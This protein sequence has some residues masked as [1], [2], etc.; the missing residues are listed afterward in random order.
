[1]KRVNLLILIIITLMII[2]SCGNNSTDPDTEIPT[3]SISNPIDNAVLASNSIVTITID[4]QDN[5]E[6]DSLE[7]YID[8]TLVFTDEESPYQYD[9]DTTDIFGEH[10]IYAK[11]FDSSD[12]S[13]TSAEITVTLINQLE[14]LISPYESVI[15]IDEELE[16]SIQVENVSDLF[17]FSAEIVFDNSIIEP[18]PDMLTI[19]SIWGNDVVELIVLENGRINVAISLQQTPGI[20]E[21]NGNEELLTFR[22]I[23]LQAGSS[24]LSFENVQMLDENGETISNFDDL[25]ITNGEITIE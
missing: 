14:L 25:E 21:I 2:I 3:I 4:A 10:T 11:A 18:V 5:E 9:W 16:V 13:A 1:M 8:S 19:G 7:L 24:S 15:S 6:I 12:N 22:V 23:G 20:D 17:A